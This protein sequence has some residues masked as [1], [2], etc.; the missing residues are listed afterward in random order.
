MNYGDSYPNSHR[1]NCGDSYL[2]FR[3]TNRVTVTLVAREEF[4]DSYLILQ[5]RKR[6]TV[7][8]IAGVLA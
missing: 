1:N 8:L 5:C 7:T 2:I 3:R 4:G 6:V